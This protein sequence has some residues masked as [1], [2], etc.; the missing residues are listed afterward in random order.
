MNKSNL[1]KD[2]AEKLL[3]MC[4]EC[5]VCEDFCQVHE[6]T[7]NEEDSPV[8]RLKAGT[9]VLK[10]EEINSEEVEGIYNCLKCGRCK[11]VCPEDI[12]IPLVVRSA[13]AR[14]INEGIGP[15]EKPEQIMKGIQ[16]KG[17]AVNGDPTERLSW[18]PEEPPENSSDTL[19]YIGCIGSYL[20][21]QAA[22]S[23]YNL[24]KKLGVN[25]TILEDEGCCGYFYYHMGKMD[26]ARKHF[27]KNVEKFKKRGIRRIITICAG[28]YHNFKFWYPNLLGDQEF[29]VIHI[30]Q[31]LPSLLKEKDLKQDGREMTYLDPCGLGRL[32]DDAYDPPREVLRLSG[33]DL[34]EMK[35]KKELAGC[36][37][38]LNINSFK[39]ISA[40]IAGDLLNKVETDT[41]VTSCTFCLF[42]LNYGLR[43][44]DLDKKILYISEVPLKALR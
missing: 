26:L 33:V 39:K 1:K 28:C 21:P 41:L 9:K 20:Y 6:T 8:S 15:K 3:D 43:K 4:L 44:S 40:R 13:Q 18:L 23:S 38:A 5:D 27:Q 42:G 14:L 31:L 2:E 24:L 30:S 25:F 19:L 7:K 32:G 35:Q 36:C 37:G 11:S 12:D 16:T 34:R 10:G 17:N 29:E 22:L